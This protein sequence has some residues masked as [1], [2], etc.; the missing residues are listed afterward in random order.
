MIRIR[1]ESSVGERGEAEVVE[2]EE[3]GL[4]QAGETSATT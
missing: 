2:N 4:G 1:R 3:L